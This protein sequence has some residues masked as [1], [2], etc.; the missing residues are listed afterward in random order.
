MSDVEHRIYLLGQVGKALFNSRLH[1]D[2]ELRK[3]R[4]LMV[5]PQPTP[6]EEQNIL[7]LASLLNQ[8]QGAALLQ[9]PKLPLLLA[10]TRDCSPRQVFLFTQG[11]HN[12][13]YLEFIQKAIRPSDQLLELGA[14]FGL[15]SILALKAGAAKAVAVEPHP[16]MLQALQRNAEANRVN[17][18][19]LQGCVVPG[20]TQGET[21]FHLVEEA[22][23]SNIFEHHQ[24]ERTD[25]VPVP[26]VSVEKLLKQHQPTVLAMDIQ[27][28]EL[29]L[30]NK[31]SLE[32]VRELVIAIHTPL[33]GEKATAETTAAITRHGFELRDIAGWVFHF[34]R[35]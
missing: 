23:A 27:G 26:V 30:F 3:G 8:L 12:Q 13:R 35:V 1:R 10:A 9:H 31:L 16:L 5:Y 19:V 22:W 34:S 7:G 18:E 6:E 33:L 11:D 2:E 28:A 25:S 21:T 29:G 15:G 14:G 4:A 24:D 17:L 32:S 20:Q